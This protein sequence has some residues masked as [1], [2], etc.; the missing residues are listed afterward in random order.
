[1]VLLADKRLMMALAERDLPFRRL[2][3]PNMDRARE[4]VMDALVADLSVRRI[5]WKGRLRFQEALHL[6]LGLKS[7]LA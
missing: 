5:G 6:D 3:M 1:M 7:P 2:D 4:L